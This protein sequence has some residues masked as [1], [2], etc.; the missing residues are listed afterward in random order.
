MADGS[1]QGRFVWYDLMTSD[2]DSAVDF[3]TRLVDW[4]TTPWQGGGDPYTMWTNDKVPLGGIMSIP[5]PAKSAGAPPYWIA[6]VSVPDVRETVALT[7]KLS[8]ANG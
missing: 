4:G 7:E 2:L 8:M 1:S 3:Y 6:Y 5:E